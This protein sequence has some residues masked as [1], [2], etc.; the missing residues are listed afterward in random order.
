MSEQ[1][2]S[3]VIAK[4][5]AKLK[6]QQK[7][8]EVLMNAAEQRTSEG[9]SAMELL[10]QNL[11]ME[12]IIQQKTEILQR[13]GEELKKTLQALQLSQTRLLQAQKL[14]SVGQ[15]AAGIAHEINTPTQFISSNIDFLKDSFMNVK[16]LI[17]TLQKVLQTIV[18]GAAIPETGREAEKQ[19]EELDWN[20]LKEEIPAAI[21]QS[22]EG[23]KRVTTIVQAMK[24]FSHPGSKEKA[25]YDLH[26]ILETTITVASN[27][28]KYCAEIV[29]HLDENFPLV[30]C[31]ANEI[32]QVFLNILINASH[33]IASK[34]RDSSEKGLITIS[35]RHA[36]EYVEICIEDTGIGIPEDIRSRVFDPFFTTKSVG[37]GTGQGLAI[38][39]DVIEN[40][41]GG[42]LSFTSEAGKGTVFTIQLPINM[43]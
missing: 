7:T 17:D 14:E 2:D 8:I 37:K 15:L 12:R 1:D 43:K 19:L 16:H 21:Q 39:H 30:F 20:Y 40:K 6:A 27:E 35:T 33:S 34:N 9:P 23:I 28:W 31:L 42:T 26:K 29:T 22:Q 36:P 4:L 38:S 5:Q 11:N 32:G 10:S 25:F 18:Q 24:E 13:Q 3:A 41:H